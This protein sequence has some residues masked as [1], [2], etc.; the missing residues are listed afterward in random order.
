MLKYIGNQMKNQPKAIVIIPA[1][2]QSKR[3]SLKN[4]KT[5]GKHP[6][7]AHSILYAKKYLDQSQMDL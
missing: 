7:L 1:R 2:G 3:L 5:F 6:L 4:S